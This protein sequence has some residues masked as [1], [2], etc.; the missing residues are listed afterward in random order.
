MT[1]IIF[2][3]T[4]TFA[5]PTLEKL[6]ENYEIISVVTQPDRPAGRK[7]KLTPPPVKKAALARG[8]PLWQPDTLRAPE[9]VAHLR[10]LAPDLIIVVAFGQILRPDVLQIPPHGC[11]N[12]HGSLL[13]QYRG[14]APALA[15]I[16][17]GEAETGV[18]LMKMDQG[19]DTGPIIA[20]AACPIAAEETTATLRKKLCHLGAKLLIE[21]LP[22]WLAGEIAPQPQDDSQ[23]SYCRLIDKADG[24]LDWRQPAVKLERQVRACIPWPT[25]F[26][27]WRGKRL[28]VLRA[29]LSPESRGEGEPGRVIA[30]G[31]GAGVV[32]G[33]GVLQLLELQ[34]SG[35]RVMPIKEFL[36][37]QRG[38]VGSVLEYSSR[39]Q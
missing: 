3:G 6:A 32:T 20:Q 29:A 34:L 7:R 36:Q 1:R 39:S 22:A 24:Q 28:K 27:F 8:L 12:L 17:N 33:K 14:P 2:M 35:K 19:L 30:L 38:F 26:S 18:T 25:A 9:A 37:G 5:L 21:T 4:P 10:A 11:L 31:G 16:L 23:A 13:P 15:A